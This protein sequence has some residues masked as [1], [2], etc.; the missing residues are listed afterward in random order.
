MTTLTSSPALIVFPVGRRLSQWKTF[1]L[2]LYSTDVYGDLGFQI[3]NSKNLDHRGCQFKTSLFNELLK[4]LGIYCIHTMAYHPQANGMVEWF[5]RQ[6]KT[7]LR[8]HVFHVLVWNFTHNIKESLL[9]SPAELLFGTPFT[10]PAKCSKKALPPLASTDYISRLLSF[11]SGIKFVM[12]RNTSRNGHLF[13]YLTKNPEI[14]SV[15]VTQDP[16][17]C[18]IG[19][20]WTCC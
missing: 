10:L 13:F 17:R 16:T 18:S 5:Y 6:L 11:M 2:R 3:W 20:I 1:W 8:A 19:I 14:H 7:E 9:F 12:P 15:L 4:L